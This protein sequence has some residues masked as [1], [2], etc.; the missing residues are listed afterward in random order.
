MWSLSFVSTGTTT[1]T[2][3]TMVAGRKCRQCR[4]TRTIR[5]IRTSRTKTVKLDRCLQG[6]RPTTSRP[7]SFWSHTD[8]FPTRVS[9]TT[10]AQ[11]KLYRCFHGSVPDIFV[12]VR[13]KHTYSSATSLCFV[14][15][16]D[17]GQF[18][19]PSVNGLSSPQQHPRGMLCLVLSVLSHQCYSSEVDSRELF[20][21]SYQ[22]SYWICLGVTVT[23]HFCSVKSFGLRHVNDDSNTN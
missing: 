6:E 23:Q 9:P 19:P 8:Q 11:H 3:M 4:R 10:H 2:T 17:H 12:A 21:R 16:P 7:T 18:A 15:W 1:M 20:A 14:F 22:Q 13:F 5:C